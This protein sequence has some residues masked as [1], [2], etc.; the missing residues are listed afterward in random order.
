MIGLKGPRARVCV[1]ERE[2]HFV[3]DFSQYDQFLISHGYSNLD[4]INRD[5]CIYKY[6]QV[7]SEGRDL[8][9]LVLS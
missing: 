1:R 7:N 2:M 5:P 4:H 8:M 9:S 3:N 6:M